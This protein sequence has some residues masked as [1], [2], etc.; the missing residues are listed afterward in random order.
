MRERNRACPG[1]A[2]EEALPVSTVGIL[3]EFESLWGAPHGEPEPL[4]RLARGQAVGWKPT[5]LRA[6]WGPKMTRGPFPPG[7][8][9]PGP[10]PE[11]AGPR[12][13]ARPGGG[14]LLCAAPGPPPLR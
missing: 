1:P 14:C 4:L 13:S 5:E 3:W 9:G 11:R 7:G 12:G 6:Q 10:R 8:K 2:R